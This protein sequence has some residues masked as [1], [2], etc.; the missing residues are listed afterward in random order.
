[1]PQSRSKKEDT[2]LLEDV[3]KYVTTGEKPK[4]KPS[5][6]GSGGAAKAAKALEERK[7]KLEEAMKE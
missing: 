1:M 2:S 3:W 4:P 5:T 6:L 7:R